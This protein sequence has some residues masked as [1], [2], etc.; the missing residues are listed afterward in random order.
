[1]DETADPIR[2]LHVD[3]DPAFGALTERLLEREDDRLRVTSVT[4]ADAGLEALDSGTFDCVVSDYDMPGTDGLAFLEAVR[5][6]DAEIPFV[7]FTGQGN[8]RVAGKA[9]S[10]GVTDYLQKDGGEDQYAVLA[11][12]VTNAVAAYRARR[13]AARQERINTLIR[14]IHRRLVSAPS[15]AEIERAVCETIAGSALYRFAWIGEPDPESGEVVPRTTAGDSERYLE[16]VAIY[17]D[18]ECRRGWGPAGMAVRTRE[19]QLVRDIR[20]DPSFEPWRDAATE[21]GYESVIVLP[22]FRGDLL[23]GVLA[24]YAAHPGAFADVE[25]AVLEELAG[26]VGRALEGAYVRRRLRNRERDDADVAERHYRAI[27]EGLPN[28]AVALFDT[29]MRYAV[30]GGAVFD[31]LDVS[32]AGME[33][34]TLREAHS[35]DYCEAYLHHYRAALEGEHRRFEFEYGDRIFRAHVVPVRDEAETVVAGLAMTQDVTDERAR[36]REIERQNERLEALAGVVSHDLR[37]PLNVAAGRLEMAREEC[38]SDHLDAVARAHDRVRGLLEDLLALA[39][40][41]R[42]ATEVGPVDLADVAEAAWRSVETAGAAPEIR[43]DRVVRADSTRLQQLLENLVRNSVEHGSTSPSPQARK[44]AVEHGARR[45]SARDTHG[46]AVEHGSTSPRSHAHEDAVERSS[47]SSRSVSGDVSEGTSASDQRPQDAG[48]AAERNPET[49]PTA[50]NGE[51]AP[52]AVTVRFGDLEDGFY[53]EDDGPGIPPERR[54]AVLEPG[55]STAPDGTG[56]GLN[57]VRRIAEAHDWTLSVTE[58]ADGGARFEFR[59]V[60]FES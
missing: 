58:G 15:V 29:D 30:V 24:I 42:A 53:V 50:P 28:G 59:G 2:V 1:M 41:D 52:A 8:E 36:R 9:I 25:R 49:P 35:R 33:G 37:N 40:E 21:Y 57:I 22:L 45:A 26:T 46:D 3:D 17:H 39:R 12:R 7:L 23:H 27:A 19:T 10:A 13:R 55:H 34:S 14:E 20:E 4:D 51:G 43:T 38:E 44:D 60:E 18:E 11:N 6:R 16:E 32:A 56:F 5:D 54:E 48:D 31:D 47:A